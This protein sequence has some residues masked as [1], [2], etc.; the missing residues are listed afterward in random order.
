MLAEAL[1]TAR[2]M[3]A[4]SA[5]GLRMTKEVLNYNLDAPSLEAAIELENRNQSICCFTA[6]FVNAVIAFNQKPE[7]ES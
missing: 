5:S 2:A 7:N 4:K 1:T 3:L 6:D